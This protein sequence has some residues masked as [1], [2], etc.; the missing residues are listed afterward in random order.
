M[1]F[2]DGLFPVEL[3]R[4]ELLELLERELELVPFVLLVF[5]RVFVVVPLLVVWLDELF[6]VPGRVPPGFVLPG[7]VGPAGDPG[8][9]PF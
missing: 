8:T 3:V 5:L 7:E 1:L 9:P 4:L 6:D 2:P